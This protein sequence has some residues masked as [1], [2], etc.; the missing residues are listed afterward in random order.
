MPGGDEARVL[1]PADDKSVAIVVGESH[2][3]SHAARGW[4]DS[5]FESSAA[6]MDSNEFIWRNRFGLVSRRFQRGKMRII[7]HH[8]IC[9]RGNCAV[10]E[11]V[12]IRVSGD[13]RKPE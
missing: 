7:R 1:L 5:P 2:I 8:K 9:S 13:D 12:V 10:A 6:K 3:R 4:T 11:F